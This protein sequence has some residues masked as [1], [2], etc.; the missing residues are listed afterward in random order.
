M[1]KYVTLRQNGPKILEKKIQILDE[2]ISKKSGYRRVVK[3]LDATKRGNWYET[4]GISE[5]ICILLK[6]LANMLQLN[7]QGKT[8]NGEKNTNVHIKSK[9]TCL[10]ISEVMFYAIIGPGSQMRK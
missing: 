3:T 8:G 5:N 7:V 4:Y 1:F 6:Y 2:N 10:R 9:T